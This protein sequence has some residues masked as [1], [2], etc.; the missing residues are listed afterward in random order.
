MAAPSLSLSQEQ[1]TDARIMRTLSDDDSLDFEMSKNRSVELVEPM[2]CT[3]A[4]MFSQVL[5]A[6]GLQ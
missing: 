4:L 5:T 2:D 1:H 3:L 6:A